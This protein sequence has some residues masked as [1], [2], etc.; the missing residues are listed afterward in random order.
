[1]K[2]GGLKTMITLERE[3]ERE[4]EHNLKKIGGDV[5]VTLD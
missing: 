1:M 2:K 3:R 5:Y 4:R